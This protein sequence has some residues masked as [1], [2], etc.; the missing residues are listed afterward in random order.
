MKV[1]IKVVI[2]LPSA[3]SYSRVCFIKYTWILIKDNSKQN[4][5]TVKQ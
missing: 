5:T 1:I 4:K 2:C 3:K